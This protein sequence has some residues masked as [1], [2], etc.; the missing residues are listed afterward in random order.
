MTTISA[1]NRRQIDPDED[2]NPAATSGMYDESRTAEKAVKATRSRHNPD[3]PM[4]LAMALAAALPPRFGFPG[5]LDR[6]ERMRA[7]KYM[8]QL[9]EENQVTPEQVRSMIAVFIKT[10][11]SSQMTSPVG[12]FWAMRGKLLAEI[13][14]ASPEDYSWDT[15][16]QA[17]CNSSVVADSWYQQ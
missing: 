10:V 15:P 16:P 7:C 1:R 12:L 5:G 6:D 17:A 9:L 2:F 13:A 14:P 4:G 11:R 8:S 3:T